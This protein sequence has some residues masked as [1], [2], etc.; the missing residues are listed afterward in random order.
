MWQITSSL[1][2]IFLFLVLIAPVFGFAQTPT[3][4]KL[5]GKVKDEYKDLSGSMVLVQSTDTAWR[6]SVSSLG[7]FAVVLDPMK[8][9]AI[10]FIAE[11]Y[12]PQK[13]EVNT[14][15]PKE[16]LTGS[17]IE[18]PLNDIELFK[19]LPGMDN[20]A[21][22]KPIARIK[23]N[24]DDEWLG[25][26]DNFENPVPGLLQTYKS[27]KQELFNKLITEGEKEFKAGNYEKAWVHYADAGELD[28]KQKTT[29]KKLKEIK[30]KISE[31][32]SAEVSFK[33]A[34]AKGDELVKEEEFDDAITYYQKAEFFN[35]NST[36]PT[37]KISLAQTKKQEAYS[38]KRD[39]Y[40][41]LITQGDKAYQNKDFED[42]W[43]SYK[44]ALRI[45][46][47]EQYPAQKLEELKSITGDEKAYQSYVE[48]ADK[49]L[50]DKKLDK[51]EE[52][53]NKAL[54]IKDQEQYPVAKIQEIKN[55]R[56]EE[57]S[58]YNVD[59]QVNDLIAEAKKLEKMAV[60]GTALE[61]MKEAQALKP[62]DSNLN[63][64]VAK[65]TKLKEN[66]DLKKEAELKE[67]R[68]SKLMDEA[69]ALFAKSELEKAKKKYAEASKL[70]PE[71]S[72]PKNRITEINEKISAIA[73][74][75]KA[76]KSAN[77]GNTNI[78]ANNANNSGSDTKNNTDK[79]NSDKSNP[80]DK[81]TKVQ[82]ENNVASNSASANLSNSDYS[83]QDKNT[84]ANQV[85]AETNSAAIENDKIESFIASLN[86]A[87]QMG[88][89]SEAMKLS[90][91]IGDA[92][93]Q[94]K[95]YKDAISYYEKS[96]KL[97]QKSNDEKAISD[98]YL[99]IG[100]ANRGIQDLQL[101]L[102]YMQ[103]ALE[104]K[105]RAFDTAGVSDV[106]SGFAQ[107]YY[108]SG[109]YDNAV[110]YYEKA[111]S[112]KESIGDSEACSNLMN[113]LGDV[114]QSTFRYDKSIECYERA[115]AM[116][117][118]ANDDRSSSV[119][120]N[121]IGNVYYEQR[122][123]DKAIEYYSRSL[124]KDS[125]AGNKTDIAASMN[126]IGVM[127]YNKGDFEKAIEYQ[128]N[129]LKINEETGQQKELSISYNNLGN[130]NFDWKKYQEALDY[131]Q[132]S[133]QIKEQI[134]YK[135]G[136]AISLFNIGNVHKEL[137]DFEKAIDYFLRSNNVAENI[138]FKEIISA[139]FNALADVYTALK[140]YKTA[141]DYQKKYSESLEVLDLRKGMQFSEMQGK[142]DTRSKD[143]Q[144]SVLKEEIR[145]HKILAELEATNNE[146]LLQ[147]KEAE[148]Q[149][150][151][152]KV[153]KQRVVLFSFIL[154]FLVILVFSILLYRQSSQRRKANILLA[155]KNEEIMQQKEEIEAQRD[156][157][158][159]QRDFV[160]MQKN[161][162]EEQKKEIMDSIVYA[163]LIQSAILTPEEVIKNMVEN[164]FILFRP[165]DIVSGDFYLLSEKFN[166]K[167]FVV[168]DCTG[169]GVPG[170]FMSMLGISALN[171]IIS[172]M[173]NLSSGE[174]L[175]QLRASI[176]K[177]LH[178]TGKEGESK[179]GMDITLC[180]FDDK[181]MELQFSGAFNPLIIIRNNELIET[182]GD[183][184]PIGISKYIDR[185]FAENIVPV[186][187]DDMVYLFT[188]GIVDQFGGDDGKKLKYPRLRN[189]LSELNQ[190]PVA[191][192]KELL[193]KR[194]EDWKG[195]IEQ[196]DDVCVM[197]FR[198]G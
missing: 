82:P 180:I 98:L 145:K 189:M 187:K 116:K 2:K 14:T 169:H 124:A 123:Y 68:Y 55:I 106:F 53:Y 50:A 162:I 8:T 40:D 102:D 168:A 24:A 89:V 182:K 10:S 184:M 39:R 86:K 5:T 139:N 23:W 105:Q 185:P 25:Y 122:D 186:Q 67:K 84:T 30:A 6:Q 7:S 15:V 72:A 179:D 155:K 91:T 58:K 136:I 80:T 104:L 94:S 174:I 29:A 108:D 194:F 4:I 49:Y 128:T 183:R 38:K 112:L 61:K 1:R 172:R 120:L 79:T 167:I 46:K 9:Y 141:L 47:D 193:N 135:Q 54:S 21:L 36:E 97:A 95:R 31:T 101:A 111:I 177:S 69:D 178:Q 170:A 37:T 83:S 156:E 121:N 151:L 48:K 11:G 197:G 78:A 70:K 190:S 150:Q 160:L 85:N 134:D 166:K 66:D 73:A 26:D 181:K 109:R 34:L 43:T 59:K 126:N 44:D 171:D 161:M 76:A 45:F 87:E 147:M 28:Q 159:Y 154:G 195:S 65:L 115:L 138:S 163:S 125:I 96:L 90:S 196:I 35:P 142:Y 158:E 118:K 16:E 60:Y 56:E 146:I 63:E 143:E 74:A 27:K 164:Y 165:R 153:Q 176:V 114:L 198:I 33:N 17:T 62:E 144:I 77:T 42:A 117:E 51:A 57:N 12:A 3:P 41:I 110:D 130:I 99:K 20:S 88:N 52:Y 137:K 13:L 157:I 113:D 22:E 103:K 93:E 75:E 100:K 92:Y 107:V 173:D 133:L 175:N 131:Y 129:S 127:Y 152:T 140:D 119:L 148:L 149:E 32:E 18:Q 188:D 192:Q 81:T 191:E 71:A 64:Y 19:I 132:K